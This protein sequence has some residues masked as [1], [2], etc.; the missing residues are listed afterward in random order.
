MASLLVPGGHVIL[1]CPYNEDRYESNVY[2]LP[3][4]QRGATASYVCQMFSSAQLESWLTTGL[5]L[6]DK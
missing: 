5:E 4:A 6:V 2:A 3:D 1:T